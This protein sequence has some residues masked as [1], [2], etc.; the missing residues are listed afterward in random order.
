MNKKWAAAGLFWLG[1][2]YPRQ[3]GRTIKG[4][5]LPHGRLGLLSKEMDSDGI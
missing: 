2:I 4:Y 3:P 1:A 5:A